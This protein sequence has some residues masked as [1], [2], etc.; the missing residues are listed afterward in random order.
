MKLF[1]TTK[2]LA[3]LVLFSGCTE[4]PNKPDL[5]MLHLVFSGRATHKQSVLWFERTTYEALVQKRQYLLRWSDK[6]LSEARQAPEGLSV[7]QPIAEIVAAGDQKPRFYFLVRGIGP[8]ETVFSGYDTD[9]QAATLTILPGDL[10][11]IDP[12]PTHPLFGVTGA[13]EHTR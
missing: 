12:R 9:P 8:D 7:K 13:R 11:I 3:V 1:S 4:V 5:E 2:V 10:L 6:G